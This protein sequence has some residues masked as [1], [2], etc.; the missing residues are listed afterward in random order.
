MAEGI[1]EELRD[2]DI[3][4]LGSFILGWEDQMKDDIER[5]IEWALRLKCDAYFFAC[6]VP[7]PNTSGGERL[8]DRVIEED[9]SKWGSGEYLVWEHPNIEREWLEEKVR[10]AYRRANPSIGRIARIIAKSQM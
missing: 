3:L 10:E 4:I 7:L 1:T 2:N 6:Y 9:P 5:E 8:K